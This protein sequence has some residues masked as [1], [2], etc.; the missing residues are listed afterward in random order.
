M[1]SAQHGHGRRTVRTRTVSW[2]HKL[3]HPCHDASG[4]HT[5]AADCPSRPLLGTLAGARRRDSQQ[6]APSI[7]TFAPTCTVQ[8]MHQV[9]RCVPGEAL[10]ELAD[11]IDRTTGTNPVPGCACRAGSHARTLV[12]SPEMTAPGHCTPPNLS[13]CAGHPV[14]GGAEDPAACQPSTLP[15]LRPGAGV[16]VPRARC[17]ARLEP[18]Q[19]QPPLPSWPVTWPGR[20]DDGSSFLRSDCP[21]LV[22]CGPNL[23]WRWRMRRLTGGTSCSTRVLVLAAARRRREI[24]WMEDAMP[25]RV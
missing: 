19:A 7:R 1:S 23:H 11:M 9:S 6:R 14:G 25:L 8:Y 18:Q 20:F 5:L 12:V 24:G 13:E 10:P 2:H 22:G 4:R 3:C 17:Q 21:A 15:G 16:V